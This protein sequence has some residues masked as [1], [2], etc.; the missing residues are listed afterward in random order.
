MK[1]Q[2]IFLLLALC[3][4]SII[5]GPAYRAYDILCRGESIQFGDSVARPQFGKIITIE[6]TGTPYIL[7]TRFGLV[8]TEEGKKHVAQ[9]MSDRLIVGS[10]VRIVVGIYTV[11]KDSGT[12]NVTRIYYAI[13]LMDAV[14]LPK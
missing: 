4:V 6:D 8:Q 7:T 3:M 2:K 5:A 13:P 9:I 11:V 14:A 10:G 12:T 1:I